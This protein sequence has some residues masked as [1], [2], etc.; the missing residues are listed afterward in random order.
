MFIGIE[1]KEIIINYQDEYISLPDE[2]QKK[3]D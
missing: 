2:I 3:I 1:N